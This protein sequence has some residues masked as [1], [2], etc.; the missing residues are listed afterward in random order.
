MRQLLNRAQRIAAR[1][2]SILLNG[3]TGAGKTHLARWIHQASPRS[4]GP[5]VSIN[6]GSLPTN[7]IE[8]ELFGHKKGAFTGA[9]EDREGKFAFVQDGTLLLDEIDALTLPAQSKLLRVL[10]EGVFERVGCNKSLPFRGRLIAASNGS[11]EEL[12]ERGQFRADLFYRLNVVQFSVPP[13]RNRMEEIR[14]LVR[15]FL[16][17]LAKKHGISVPTIDREVW[18]AFENYHWPGNLRELR[19]AIE[20]AL[21]DCEGTMIGVDQLPPKFRSPTAAT[22]ASGTE[23]SATPIPAAAEVPPRN[24]LAHARQMGEYRYLLGILEMCD[25]N[26][27][28]AARALGISRTALYKKLG[29]FGIS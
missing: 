4:S 12:I 13:L 22:P 7:L 28:Q 23:E 6:C 8:S 27:S 29:S 25:N 9:D 16:A 20:H 10:D 18:H 1:D 24:P 17:T 11:L 21:A 19:N 5:F 15:C 2:V 26:R 3:E 14:P